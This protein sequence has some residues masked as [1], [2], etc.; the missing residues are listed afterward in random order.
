MISSYNT[1]KR[2]A[3]KMVGRKLLINTDVLL[4]DFL[5]FYMKQRL[6]NIEINISKDDI[7]KQGLFG[8]LTACLPVRQF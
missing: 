1:S 2:N 4:L 3:R 7:S 8:K 5:L 6:S